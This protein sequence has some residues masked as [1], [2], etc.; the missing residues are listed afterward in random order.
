MPTYTYQ[1]TNC[2]EEK[3]YIH[4]MSEPKPHC[5]TCQCDTL[6]QILTP[7][8]FILHGSGWYK[9]DYSRID[10]AKKLNQND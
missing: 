4:K 2:K 3:D 8:T 7:S 9:T 6:K 10:Q 1:C 5:S